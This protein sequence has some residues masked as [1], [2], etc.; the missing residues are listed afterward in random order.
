MNKVEID[1]DT[2]DRIVVCSLKD[3]ILMLREDIK[4][5]RSKKRLSDWEK[6]CVAEAFS[7]LDH[8]EKTFDYYGGK[9]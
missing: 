6:M 9:I 4:K 5:L 2:A 1:A 3:T 7:S 8:L